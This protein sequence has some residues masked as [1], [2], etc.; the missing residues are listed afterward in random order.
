MAVATLYR[1]ELSTVQRLVGQRAKRTRFGEWRA[2]WNSG[3][4]TRARSGV[5]G[6]R[7][8]GVMLAVSAEMLTVPPPLG[9]ERHL[10]F[11]RPLRTMARATAFAFRSPSRPW[12]SS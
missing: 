11:Q 7:L 10:R 2:E 3:A 9:V 4:P 5:T 12:D 6:L 8:R 1:V